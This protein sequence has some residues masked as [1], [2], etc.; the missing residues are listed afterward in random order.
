MGILYREFS[1]KNIF[2]PSFAP[3][4]NNGTVYI[5][6]RKMFFVLSFPSM[7]QLTQNINNNIKIKSET[8]KYKSE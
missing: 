7:M 1:I 5:F 2:F 6:V 4:V 3:E 8:E